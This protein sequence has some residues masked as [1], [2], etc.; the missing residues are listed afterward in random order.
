MARWG[1]HDMNVW[2]TVLSSVVPSTQKSY[3]KIFFTFVSFFE[4]RGLD[5]R[6]ISIE[7]VLSFLQSFVGK[8]KSRVRTGVAALKMYLRVYKRVDLADHPL[9]VLFS[10]GAQNLAPLPRV[11]DTIWN[12]ETVLD[13]LKSQ[14]VP[15]SF[16][17]CAR[18]SITLLLLATG[19]RVDDVWKLDVKVEISD[20][21]AIFFFREKRKCPVKKQWTLS[22]AV[23]RF[24]E[25]ERICPV[26]AISLFLERAQRVR[27]NSESPFLFVSTTGKRASKD[28]LRRW[29]IHLLLSAGIKASAGSCRSASTS[30]AN[31]KNRSIDEI[32]RSAGWS[33]ESTFRRYY[34]RR[35]LKPVTPLNLFA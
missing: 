24:R 29:V 6:S 13:W 19:W 28:T 18:E 34:D 11:K 26:K 4:A 2:K 35:V 1:I 16:L 33:S 3:E 31:A 9:L 7:T 10:K 32:L 8:S 21:A 5:F 23:P 12:P 20:E 25:S 17:A 14:P 22:Q 30:A 27:K 15:V